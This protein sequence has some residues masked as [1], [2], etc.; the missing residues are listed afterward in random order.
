M[1]LNEKPS[2]R[3]HPLTCQVS[4][5]NQRA[6]MEAELTSLDSQLER[7]KLAQAARS[8]RLEADESL[9]N[10]PLRKSEVREVNRALFPNENRYPSL[11]PDL[12]AISAGVP[13]VEQWTPQLDLSHEETK[14]SYT[15]GLILQ[16]L[17]YFCFS[18]CCAVYECCRNTI[19]SVTQAHMPTCTTTAL[20]APCSAYLKS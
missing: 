11:E 14:V 12:D 3:T 7:A 10:V 20:F 4:K 19:A 16:L 17:Y 8:S 1:Y 6:R 18:D 2:F 5:V 13:K 15:S 9:K